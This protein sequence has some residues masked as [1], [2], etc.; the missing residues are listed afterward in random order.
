[1]LKSTDTKDAQYF[2]WRQS[3]VGL[4]TP[5]P[6][7]RAP[8]HGRRQQPTSWGIRARPPGPFLPG[9]YG[10]PEHGA[11]GCADARGPVVAQRAGDPG[12]LDLG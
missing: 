8:P 1:M 9:T 7:A 12:L 2:I 3:C 4:E 5:P 11:G 10:P 6:R